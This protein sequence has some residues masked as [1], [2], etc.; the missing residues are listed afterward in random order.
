VWGLVALRWAQ[1]PLALALAP[2]MLVLLKSEEQL[3]LE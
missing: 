2:V 1:E 3:L